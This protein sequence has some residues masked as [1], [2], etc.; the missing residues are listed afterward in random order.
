MSGES[1]DK[2]MRDSRV[3]QSSDAI[4]NF[5]EAGLKPSKSGQFSD[6]FHRGSPKAKWRSQI[7]KFG[8][9]VQGTDQTR[10][11]TGAIPASAANHLKIEG[12]TLFI[13]SSLSSS[14][15][16]DKVGISGT[17]VAT[18]ADYFYSSSA[19]GGRLGHQVGFLSASGHSMLAHPGKAGTLATNTGSIHHGGWHTGSA[20]ITLTYNKAP[21][22]D[23]GEL[24]LYVYADKL[25]RAFE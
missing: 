3:A 4:E 17:G 21:A 1:R 25:F 19:E 6:I 16:I 10:T 14:V 5:K 13:T 12:V 7:F 18:D 9:F 23:V 8:P 11:I 24:Y 15:Y 22:S 2:A 20:N